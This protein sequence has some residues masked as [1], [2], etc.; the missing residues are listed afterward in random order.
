MDERSGLTTSPVCQKPE[1]MPNV[2]WRKTNKRGKLWHTTENQNDRLN[3]LMHNSESYHTQ[4]WL[5]TNS[6]AKV[7]IISQTGFNRLT[8]ITARTLSPICADWMCFSI[9]LLILNIWTFSAPGFILLCCIQALAI[10]LHKI[11]GGVIIN[12]N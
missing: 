5:L 9:Y 8:G 11:G 12:T 1:Q 10:I 7:E 6:E 3:W 4:V 2:W